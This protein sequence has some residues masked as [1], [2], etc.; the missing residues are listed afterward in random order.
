M[1]ICLYLF[2]L[3][4]T[5][6]GIIAGIASISVG[7]VFGP[8]VQTRKG[9]V[10]GLRM[11]V[12]GKELDV[13]YGIPFAR[14]PLGNLRFKHPQPIDPWGGVLNATKKPNSCWQSV[15]TSGFEGA[16]VWNPNTPLDEDCLYLNVWVPK[17]TPPFQ[18]KS[19]MV[20]I[21]GGGFVAGTA[22]LD[23]YDAKYIAAEND[24]IVV[25]MQYRVGSLGFLAM[26]HR[27][28]PGNAGMFDQLMAL[29]WV[30]DNIQYFGGNRDDVTIFGESAGAVSVGMH[31][32]SPMSRSLFQRAILQSA[33]PQA[34]WAVLPDQEAK[35]RSLKLAKILGCGQ[36]EVYEIVDCLRTKPANLFPANEYDVI[37]YGVVRFPFVP[38]V[39]GTF[40]TETPRKAMR[41]GHF[42]KCPVLIGNTLNEASYWMHYYDKEI[43]PKYSE[44]DS[45]ISS[46]QFGILVDD[47]FDY[48][49][50]YPKPLNSFGRE[51]ILFEYTPWKNP[52][53]QA[54]N[55]YQLDMA[56]GDF[57]FICPSVD[58]AM[59]YAKA[60]MNVY[61]YVFSHRSSTH[62]WADW[63]GIMHGD[64]INFVFGEPLDES[65]KYRHDEKIFARKVMKYWTNFAKSGDPNR[66]PGE[67]SLDEWPLYTNTTRKHIVLRADLINRLD[68]SRAIQEGPRIRQCAF[69]REYLPSLTVKTADMSE[70]EV[71][72]KVQFNEWSTKYIVDWKQ[73]FDSFMLD[74][75][76][77]M[78]TCRP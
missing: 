20:W 63:M 31:L 38:I 72:W 78:S 30:R 46:H 52:D 65:K 59:E 54:M 40:L 14:P 69:W 58:F 73:Q 53:D 29:H 1:E 41:N 76:E 33:G 10:K 48:H 70:M 60:G 45:S 50:Y 77:R 49:P 66:S 12:L 5:A 7:D 19:V 27:E 51:A 62:Y 68:K 17:T 2:K 4:V 36:H 75:N 6:V 43:F 56:I 3:Y 35:N 18:D 37:K 47:L 42:K 39:D 71:E 16:E 9:R 24:I 26:F 34:D 74:H 67:L 25:S 64:E 32:L 44:T 8:I 57:N 61:Y 21:F 28:S 15:D 22:T 13:F 55:R 23:V 11:N